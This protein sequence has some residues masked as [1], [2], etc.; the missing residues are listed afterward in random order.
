MKKLFTLIAIVFLSCESSAPDKKNIIE[1]KVNSINENRLEMVGEKVQG[2]FNGDKQPE[3]ATAVRFAEEHGNPAEGG[4]AAEYHL[5]F[6]NANLP[7]V[8][9]SF[10][11]FRI[12]NEGDLDN[13]GGDE[14]S[15]FQE[16]V[17]GCVYSM[18]TY[19]LKNNQ[20]QQIVKPFLIMTGCEY[21]SNE[22]LQKRIFTENNHIYFWDVDPNDENN[23]LIR[24]QVSV[25][26]TNSFQ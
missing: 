25:S 6:T 8:A 13:D 17:N 3:F 20:W 23:L 2:D 11:S 1:K 26:K 12:I 5:Q 24:K 19:S 15:L 9:V 4:T 16:P 10:N 22:E 7:S 18:T 14:L 21:I